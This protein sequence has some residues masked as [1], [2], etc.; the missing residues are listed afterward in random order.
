MH[1]ELLKTWLVS[2]LLLV[3]FA[4]CVV[5]FGSQLPVYMTKP[6]RTYIVRSIGDLLPL[7]FEP[8]SL[9]QPR[10]LCGRQQPQQTDPSNDQGVNT[11]TETSTEL[12]MRFNGHGDDNGEIIS[13]QIRNGNCYEAT[14]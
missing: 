3:I 4:V 6:D 13:K 7:A 14:N 5:Q 1:T 11:A 9:W 12:M 8:E 10:V 2:F